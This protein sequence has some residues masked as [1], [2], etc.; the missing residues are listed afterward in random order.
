MRSSIQSENI[1]ALPMAVGLGP[2]RTGFMTE[3]DRT[4]EDRNFQQLARLM[5]NGL[6]SA[7]KLN[8][9]EFAER[10]LAQL[11]GKAGLDEGT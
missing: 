6:S 3:V 8:E 10:C 11:G 1:G 5:P 9:L 4:G 2:G 7:T